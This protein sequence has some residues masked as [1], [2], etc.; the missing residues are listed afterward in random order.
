[1]KNILFSLL[2]LVAVGISSSA[3]QT[4]FSISQADSMR[5]LATKQRNGGITMIFVGSGLIVG[6]LA[7]WMKAIEIKVEEDWDW[8]NGSDQNEGGYIILGIVGYGA[9][10]TLLITGIRKVSKAHKINKVLQKANISMA[11]RSVP[12]TSG[13]GR[14]HSIPQASVSLTIPLGK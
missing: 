11:T 14:I 8:E 6:G 3:Q 9:G 4:H 7:A 5:H 13:G 1:M 12:F 2:M 10:I